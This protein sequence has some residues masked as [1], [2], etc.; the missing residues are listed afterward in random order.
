MDYT[1]LI[2]GGIVL[3]LA[4]VASVEYRLRKRTVTARATTIRVPDMRYEQNAPVLARQWDAPRNIVRSAIQNAIDEEQEDW[5][6]AV[7]LSDEPRRQ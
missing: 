1:P 6:N 2:V 7:Y 4:W 3:F 5:G